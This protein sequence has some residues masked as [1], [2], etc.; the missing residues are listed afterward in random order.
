MLRLISV[1]LLM[2]LA[3]VAEAQPRVVKGELEGALPLVRVQ[4]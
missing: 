2:A 4:K 1:P 3:G